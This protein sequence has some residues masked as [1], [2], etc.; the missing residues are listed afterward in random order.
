MTHSGGW[1]M[2]LEHAGAHWV[3]HVAEKQLTS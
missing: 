2:R 1:L 3:S